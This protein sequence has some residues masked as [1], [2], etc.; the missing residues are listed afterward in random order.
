MSPAEM[1]RQEL[2]DWRNQERQHTLEMIQKAEEELN[3]KEQMIKLTHKGLIEINTSPD[4]S[5]HLCQKLPKKI[6]TKGVISQESVWEYVDLIWP[7]CTKDMCLLSFCPQTCS[8]AV[9]YSRLYSYLNHKVRYAIINANNMEAFIIPLPA[10]QPIPAKL[11]P[12]GGPG[13]E[14][15]HPY[16]LLALLFQNH[17]F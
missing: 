7:A 1:A 6:T 9:F 8:D 15:E 11:R 2:A 17:P 12:L 10:C 4:Q 16:L 13:L 3:Q 5:A 14:E